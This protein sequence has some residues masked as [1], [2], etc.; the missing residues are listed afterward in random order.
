MSGWTHWRCSW[1]NSGRGSRGA[2]AVARGGACPHGRR[3]RHSM[4]R[5]FRGAFSARRAFAC[6][7]TGL[8]L[9]AVCPPACGAP[10][11]PCERVARAVNRSLRPG[12]DETELVQVLRALNAGEG[13]RLPPKFV[14]KRTAG[15]MGWRPGRD[16]WSVPALRGR[17]IGGDRFGNREGR[18]P[19]VAGGW[20]EADLDYRGG[21]RGA[22]RLVYSGDGGR[23]IT[24]DHYSTFTEIPACR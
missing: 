22:K 14:T 6:L 4:I 13:R 24:V 1:R 3:N 7:L 19:E 21:R 10:V 17:S 9:A 23:M 2:A 12:I 11:E 15:R 20:R 18:L 8:A 16:L 5:R